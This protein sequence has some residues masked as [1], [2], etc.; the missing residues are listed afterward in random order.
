MS[1]EKEI[2]LM[3]TLTEAMTALGVPAEEMPDG[4]TR[5]R[6]EELLPAIAKLKD[7]LD[8]AQGEVKMMA[9]IQ[10]RME[11]DLKDQFDTMQASLVAFVMTKC[12][13]KKLVLDSREITDHSKFAGNAIT[14]TALDEHSV[15]YVVKPAKAVR[16]V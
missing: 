14:V 7:K 12:G 9:A 2:S 13:R 16:D 5:I 3:Y 15:Q 6:L 8:A 4:S 1:E 10:E 11:K